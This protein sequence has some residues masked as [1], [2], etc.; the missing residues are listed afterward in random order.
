[1]AIALNVDCII[2]QLEKQDINVDIKTY[3]TKNKAD[4]AFY[5]FLYRFKSYIGIQK[6]K[7]IYSDSN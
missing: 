2:K 5:W 4:K 7:Y 1:M 6:E 3:K